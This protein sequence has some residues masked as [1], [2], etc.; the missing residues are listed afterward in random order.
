[1]VRAILVTLFQEY[2]VHSG[3]IRQRP[4]APDQKVLEGRHI[5]I[6]GFWRVGT[7]NMANIMVETQIQEYNAYFITSSQRVDAKP[8]LRA[9]NVLQVD[10]GGRTLSTWLLLWLI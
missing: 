5:F 1:M 7:I 10:S 4:E 9:D 8:Y 3:C 2:N 6:V